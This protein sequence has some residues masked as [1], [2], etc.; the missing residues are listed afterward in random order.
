[1]NN[2]PSE[3]NHYQETVVDQN[4]WRSARGT[5]LATYA[6]L[7]CIG[8]A[9]Y[10]SQNRT[11]HMGHWS[12]PEEADDVEPMITSI[13]QTSTQPS[14]LRAW[15]R[16]GAVDPEDQEYSAAVVTARAFMVDRLGATG[17]IYCDTRWS[18]QPLSVDM[19]LHCSSG[20]FISLARP[21]S[22]K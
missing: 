14:H 21:A 18:E 9:V 19:W 11:G 22:F 20:D 1:M 3:S 12:S 2:P 15:L 5:T 8:V 6:L 10:D 17:I 4:D 7:P 16:G 13:L